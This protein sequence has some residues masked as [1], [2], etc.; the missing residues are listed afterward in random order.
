MRFAVLLHSIVEY[1][2]AQQ[3]STLSYYVLMILVGRNFS[4]GRFSLPFLFFF[5]KRTLQFID[6]ELSNNRW[7]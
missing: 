3:K 2:E 7:A 6:L 5:I 1:S 4:S